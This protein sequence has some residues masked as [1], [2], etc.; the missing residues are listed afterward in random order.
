MRETDKGLCSLQPWRLNVKCEKTW[1]AAVLMWVP[2]YGMWGFLTK[3]NSHEVG[4]VTFASFSSRGGRAC[5]PYWNNDS[6][7]FLLFCVCQK[8]AGMVL[9]LAKG[10]WLWW[11]WCRDLVSVTGCFVTALLLDW[12]SAIR[13][14]PYLPKQSNS[15]RCWVNWACS[16][17]LWVS[18]LEWQ[19][20]KGGILHPLSIP[21]EN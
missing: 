16:C 11:S 5:H 20:W 7:M 1:Y 18:M 9:Y 15:S 10:T 3:N 14:L 19:L 4:K 8:E 6:F 21:R 17:W 12:L 13:I 2:G